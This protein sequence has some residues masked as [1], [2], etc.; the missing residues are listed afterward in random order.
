[1]KTSLFS[2]DLPEELI[3][4]R[5]SEDREG[6][7]LLVLEK[8]TGATQGASVRD[9]PR[10]ITP[11]TAVIL[12][13]TRVRKARLFAQSASGGRV[14]VLLLEEREPGLWEAIAGRAGRLKPG[15]ALRFPDGVSG[16]VE[17]REN[18]VRLIR[19][20]PAIDEVW[21][22]RNGHVP[23]PPYIRRQDTPDDEERYQTVFSRY[24]G[25]AAAPTAGLHFTTRL[26]EQLSAAGAR[27]GWI[28]LH[29]GLGTFLPIRAEQI[30]NHAMHEERF[31]VPS[32]TR[33]LVND[34]VREGRPVLAVGTTVV[35]TL[36]SAW[37]ADGLQEGK[38]RTRIY[39]TPGFTFRVV[40]QLFTNFH[41]PG[42]SLLVLVSAFAGRE[43]ILAA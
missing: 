15:R 22:E 11:G 9:L 18:E 28:T 31:F 16:V 41:T 29:V 10:F 19:F 12:N 30:E 32:A 40:S 33:L 20:S 2:F 23:L 35:R 26:L 37:T 7:R 27:I 6:A 17:G 8:K 1:M 24:Q 43:R 4:Q 3:A 25:S 38:G 5:P 36:E 34:A 14:E 13:D 21:M 39:V 42:S